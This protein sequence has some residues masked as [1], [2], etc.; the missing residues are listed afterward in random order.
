[1]SNHYLKDL[2]E[3]SYALV[4]VDQNPRILIERSAF[5]SIGDYTRSQ[6]TG[7][8]PGRVYRCNLGWHPDMA[9]NWFVYVCEAG[10]G[11]DE[12]W[13]VH[14]PYKAVIVDDAKEN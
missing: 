6:P 1:M 5:N 13:V 12:G 14:R 9:D 3:E 2:D 8:S 11:K 10:T 4:N 7:P